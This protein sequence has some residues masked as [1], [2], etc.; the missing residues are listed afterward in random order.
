MA[1]TRVNGADSR[2]TVCIVHFSEYFSILS[3]LPRGYRYYR[4]ALVMDR[5]GDRGGKRVFRRLS[6][7][8]FFRRQIFHAVNVWG[9]R[10]MQK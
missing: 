6:V 3:D 4:S 10:I 9:S 7:E 5:E 1:R 8:V 2:Q